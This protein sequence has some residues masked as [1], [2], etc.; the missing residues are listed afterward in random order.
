MTSPFLYGIIFTKYKREEIFKMSKEKPETKICKHCKTEIPYGAKV[1][2]QCRK[3]QGGSLKWAIIVFAAI[4]II[5]AVAG[6]GK[7]DKPVKVGDAKPNNVGTSSVKPSQGG[8]EPSSTEG[9]NKETVFQKG[10]IAELNGVHVTLTDYKESA[11]SDFNKPSDGNVFLMAEF[12]IANNTD[13]E[14]TISSMLSFEAYADD[15]AL[16]FS[17]SALIEKDGNQLDGTIAA[18]K[19]MKGWIGWEVPQDYKNME[20]HFTDNVW[21][22]NKFVFLIEK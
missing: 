4:C 18:G 11:G 1:C 17:L 9:E 5:G 19:K 8:A 3:K 13:K 12:E 10:E 14:L 22:D 2:P 6:G 16:N 15:Y 7:D 21:S 20:I